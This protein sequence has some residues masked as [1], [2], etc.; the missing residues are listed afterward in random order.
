MIA[1][2]RCRLSEQCTQ[3]WQ[4]LEPVRGNPH[5]RYCNLCQSAVHLVEHEHELVEL[6]R[7]GK[8]VAVLRNDPLSTDGGP[9]GDR[10][11]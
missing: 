3:R 6:A 2:E 4:S 8:S 10:G 11:K 5:M 7:Q 9:N 1:I